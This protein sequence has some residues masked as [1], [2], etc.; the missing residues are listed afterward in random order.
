LNGKSTWRAAH[1]GYRK[2]K[3]VDHRSH[4]CPVSGKI[5][6]N[7]AEL[8]FH[9]FEPLHTSIEIISQVFVHSVIHLLNDKT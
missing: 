9:R 6:L 7:G 1:A 3:R 5:E 2:Q 8:F 4:L